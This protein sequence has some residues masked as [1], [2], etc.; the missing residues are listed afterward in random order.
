MRIKRKGESG[1][2]SLSP[3]KGLKVLDGEPLNRIEKTS[4]GDKGHDPSYPVMVKAIQF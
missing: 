1:S 4:C 2:P 3:L